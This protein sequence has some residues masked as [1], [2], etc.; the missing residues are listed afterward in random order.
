MVDIRVILER[1]Y[2]YIYMV[3]DFSKGVRKYLSAHAWL[4]ARSHA[5]VSGRVVIWPHPHALPVLV[6]KLQ[7]RS[8]QK[9]QDV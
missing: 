8:I 5:R 7:Q 1:E 9:L 2:I 6:Q 4:H 3:S